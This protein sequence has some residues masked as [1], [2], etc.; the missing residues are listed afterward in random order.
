ML[1]ACRVIEQFARCFSC[2]FLEYRVLHLA[3]TSI[4]LSVYPTESDL[5]AKYQDD[6]KIYV[7]E[8]TEY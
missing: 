8:R 1:S 5:I 7:Y 6:F 4:D 2:D 3:A